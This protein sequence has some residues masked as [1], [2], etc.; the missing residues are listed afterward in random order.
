MIKPLQRN[1]DLLELLP[2]LR[3]C[4]LAVVQALLVVRLV[5]RARLVFVRAEML[6]FLARV[7]Y[8]CQAEGG[9]AAFEEVA[10]GGELG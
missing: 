1:L 9:R 10:E 6:D 4:L 8:F 7:F 5:F 2:R 3:N